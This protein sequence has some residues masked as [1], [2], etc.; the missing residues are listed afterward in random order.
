[1]EAPLLQ[2][3][4]AAPIWVDVPED[5]IH[6]D[7]KCGKKGG[8]RANCPVKDTQGA[9]HRGSKM[10]VAPAPPNKEHVV[11]PA[12]PDFVTDVTVPITTPQRLT[13]CT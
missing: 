12:N 4:A 13:C 3:A 5:K 8:N 11:P 2:P 1:M 7:C 9:I 10:N 6:V